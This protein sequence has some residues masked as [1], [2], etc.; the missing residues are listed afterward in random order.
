MNM[1]NGV[2]VLNGKYI[3]KELPMWLLGITV[4]FLV[5]GVCCL[6]RE[7]LIGLIS[8]LCCFICLVCGIVYMQQP[9]NIKQY[10]VTISEDVNMTEFNERYEVIKVEGKIYTIREKEK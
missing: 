9:S 5:V 1:L 6:F 4:L 7:E 2:E 10:Q 8:L 3:N